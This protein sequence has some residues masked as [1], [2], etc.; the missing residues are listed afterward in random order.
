MTLP[1]EHDPD[2]FIKRVG[3]DAMREQINMAMPLSQY[4][5]AYLSERY[6][7]SLAEGKAK[8]MSQ[9]RT[10]TNSLPKGS[11]FRYLLN[12]DI[13]QKLGG[14]RNQNS[15]AKDALLNFDGDMTISQQL[16]L[17]LLF[18]PIT[19]TDDPIESIWQQAG[20]HDLNLPTHIKQKA[21]SDVL[22][23][24]TWA[25]LQDD[26]LFDVV[27]TI[28]RCQSA[29]PTDANAAAH[30]ILSN[31][32]PITQESL[33]RS[34]GTFYKTL[35]ARNVFNLDELIETL[36]SQLLE[37]SLKKIIQNLVKNPDHIKATIVKMQAQLLS[38]WLRA[39]QAEQSAQMSS[40]HS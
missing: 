27:S 10:L 32:Q 15:E 3:V 11:S 18:Q 34:W 33:S 30:F 38:D 23:S 21:S 25:D 9:V 37:R 36:V 7:M 16:Q 4:I 26:A 17:C 6:D 39:Q 19:L 14:K 13:Y 2:T 5:F 29:L 8:L 40:A 24:L 1:N 20:I 12:N 22:R 28:Q 31:I 35:S